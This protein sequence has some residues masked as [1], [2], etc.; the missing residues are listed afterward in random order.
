MEACRCVAGCVG[1]PGRRLTL[2]DLSSESET[3]SE[4]EE[5]KYL[6]SLNSLSLH[7]LA[8]ALGKSRSLCYEQ[9]VSLSTFLSS[10]LEKNLRL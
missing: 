6:N 4:D 7:G 3:E 9:C 5:V 1:R 10:L 8:D 2:N